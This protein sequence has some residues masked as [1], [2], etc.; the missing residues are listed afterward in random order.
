[1]NTLQTDLIIIFIMFSTL[2]TKYDWKKYHKI[3]FSAL[4]CKTVFC[5]PNQF[6]LLLILFF[7][8]ASYQNN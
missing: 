8:F 3:C 7:A 2:Q 1:M 4:H 6:N 5:S